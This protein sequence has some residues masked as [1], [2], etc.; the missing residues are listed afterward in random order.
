MLKE[1][2]FQY[3][4]TVVAKMMDVIL[5]SKSIVQCLDRLGSL[6]YGH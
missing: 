5:L 1:Q 6:I 4:Y 3:E 2:N